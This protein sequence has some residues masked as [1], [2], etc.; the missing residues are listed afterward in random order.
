[1][2]RALLRT[3]QEV[4][5]GMEYIHQFNVVHGDL[6]PGNVLLRTHKVDRRGYVAKVRL[7]SDGSC[8]CQH[9]GGG[10]VCVEML[11]TVYLQVA[12]FGLSRPLELGATHA[13]MGSALGTIGY[14]APETFATNCVKKPSDVY[15][16]GILR[17]RAGGGAS[18]A[19]RR[20][21]KRWRCDVVPLPTCVFAVWEMFHCRDA[22]EGLLDYQIVCGVSE[23]M[24]RPEW[25]ERVPPV[26]RALA[27]RCW[28]T[29][30]E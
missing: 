1:M 26:Y 18:H 27:E 28:H 15:A 23:G 24:L 11:P 10:G 14:T 30:P 8:L 22:Y 7:V 17:K 2:Q 21:A 6:K 12:D 19:V 16:F 5:Q 25:D 20:A 3:A 29:D 13:S 4:A 9:C